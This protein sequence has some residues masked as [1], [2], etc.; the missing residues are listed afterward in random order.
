MIRYHAPWILPIGEPPIRDGWIAVD[1]GRVAALGPR[2]PADGAH[3]VDLG[4]VVV[5]PG[6]VNAHT[7]LELSYLRDAVPP[8][9]AFI[10]WVRGIVAAR[11][12]GPDPQAPDVLAA[13]DAAISEVVASGTAIVGD[14]SNTLTTFGP[15]ARS[16]LAAV[17]FYELMRFNAPDP[18]AVVERACREIEGL[19]PTERVHASLAAH[20]P[21][22][23]APLVLRAIR[24]AVDRDPFAP[25]SVHVSESAEE[26][27]FIRSGGGPWQALLKELGSWDPAWVPPGGTPVQFLDDS[28]FLD[29]RVRAVHGVQMT[30]ADLRRLVARGTAL[31]TCPRSNGH[32]GAGAPPVEDFYRSGVRVAIGTDSLASAPD[33][34]LFAEL[35]T[36]RALA[37]GVPAAALLDS[38]TRQGARALAF[39]GDYG[40][41]EPGKCARLITVAIP[42]GTTD[43]EEY[44]VGGIQPEQVGWIE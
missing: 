19:V 35:A 8:S 37:P 2:A 7:H 12:Q 26:M 25:C 31:V 14:V 13:I 15:L 23:V 9:A 4:E 38:A 44:L 36:M 20:A 33:L 17:V 27:E 30:N 39:D 40:T 6:L 1:R 10:T 16:P 29:A 32:T 41:I 21:Y 22:S 3:E 24:R 18:E 42:P 43:V 28:G 5:L 11:R 34:N